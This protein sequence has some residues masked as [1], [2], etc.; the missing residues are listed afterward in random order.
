[1]MRANATLITEIS[2]LSPNVESPLEIADNAV[3]LIIVL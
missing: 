1:M 2:I 3:V